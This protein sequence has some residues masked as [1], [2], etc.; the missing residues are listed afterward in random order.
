MSTV[1][2]Q[3]QTKV[4]QGILSDLL[5]DITEEDNENLANGQKDWTVYL[6]FVSKDG[7]PKRAYNKTGKYSKSAK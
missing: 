1:F 7:A 4:L 6:R 3:K 5:D 2:T